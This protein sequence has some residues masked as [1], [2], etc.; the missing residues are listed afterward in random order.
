MLIHRNLVSKGHLLC[1]HNLN[2]NKHILRSVKCVLSDK[3]YVFE[4]VVM[5]EG[6]LVLCFLDFQVHA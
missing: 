6:I 2:H 1:A 4:R 3:H 5:Q